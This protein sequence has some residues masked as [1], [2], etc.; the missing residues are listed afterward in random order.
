MMDLCC[1]LLSIDLSAVDQYFC[2]QSVY[3]L[4]L[5]LLLLL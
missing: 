2:C 1:A 3:L 4:L 5:L